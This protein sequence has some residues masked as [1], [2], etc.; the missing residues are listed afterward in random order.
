VNTGLTRSRTSDSQVPL[1]PRTVAPPQQGLVVLF[2]E[3]VVAKLGRPRA[4]RLGV[5]AQSWARRWRVPALLSEVRI[6]WNGR[7]R[8]AVARYR[9]D[10]DVIEVGP[11]F[12]LLRSRSA[13]VLAHELAH[14]AAA[15]L[16]AKAAGV[17]GPHWKD[18]VRTAGFEP[19]VRLAG[20]GR[21]R[22]LQ[23]QDRSAARYEHRCPVCQML[24]IARRPI[25]G[26]RCAGCVRAGLPGTLVIAKIEAR[27]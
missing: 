10:I 14:A 20:T 16:F 11:R 15:R 13:E 6:Q 18:L 17:H 22:P 3:D 27:R 19:Q 9:R 23:R 2:P 5:Q 25:G 4:R 12:L 1:S 8:V 26:W 24:R 21:S 7:L